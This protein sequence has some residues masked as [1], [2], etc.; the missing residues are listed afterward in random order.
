LIVPPPV[1]F[2]SVPFESVLGWIGGEP[3]INPILVEGLMA[4]PAR[5][6]NVGF[7]NMFVAFIIF[8]VS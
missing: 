5:G 8:R 1:L 3:R 7:C 6:E 2:L 4:D